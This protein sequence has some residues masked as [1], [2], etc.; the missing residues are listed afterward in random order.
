VAPES[1][2]PFSLHAAIVFV[3]IL[4]GYLLDEGLAILGGNI[5]LLT[6]IGTFSTILR[7]IPTFPLAMLGGV[8]YIA[9]ATWILAP[10]M[11]PDPWFER[12]MV[13]FGMQTGATAMGI[14]LLRIIDPG[15]KTGALE[16]FAVKQIIYEPFFGG[17]F[18]IA[19]TPFFVVTLGLPAFLIA[20]LSITIIFV[21]MGTIFGLFPNK[22]RQNA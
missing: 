2:E 18:V 9:L 15:F 20:M 10:R 16:P 4:L 13:E 11:L 22:S 12:A 5:S 17:G 14:M 1:I 8:A 6:G 19:L 7:A 3:A 21:T